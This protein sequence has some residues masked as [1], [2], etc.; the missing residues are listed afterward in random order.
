MGLNGHKQILGLTPYRQFRSS[1]S[2]F[3]V[4]NTTFFETA[5]VNSTQLRKDK[6]VS[7]MGTS[8][9]FEYKLY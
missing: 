1:N 8:F 4:S 9:Y 3:T 6:S 7:K 2:Q 5:C